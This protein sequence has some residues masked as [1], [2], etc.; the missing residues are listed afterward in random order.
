MSVSLYCQG[1]CCNSLNLLFKIM[2]LALICR[3]FLG[4]FI[5]ALLSRAYLSWDFLSELFAVLYCAC[6]TGE[7]TFEVKIEIKT[8]ADVSDDKPRPYLCSVCD[9]RFTTK[10]RLTRHTDVHTTVVYTCSSL[11][12]LSLP[13]S[14]LLQADFWCIRRLM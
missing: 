3:R 11:P 5:H 2:F 10:Q 7:S 6:Y 12:D 1:Q 9:K 14:N 4:V 8:E 13:T